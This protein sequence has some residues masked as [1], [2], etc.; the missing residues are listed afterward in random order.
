MSVGVS[1]NKIFAKMGS[2]YKKPDATTVISRENYRELLW[3]LPVTD[4]L[5]VG[6]AAA[7]V[8]E[9]YGVHTIGDLAA[10]D[11]EALGK[12]LGRQGYTL[13]DYASGAEHS[14]VVPAPSPGTWRG[15]RSCAPPSPSCPTRWPSACASTPSS[16]PP[17]R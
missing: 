16:A 11:R 17:S 5:F 3:P 1:F 13:H 4:L 12:L 9:Q 15:G 7:R 8:L 14:P 6:R 10:Y 2:D